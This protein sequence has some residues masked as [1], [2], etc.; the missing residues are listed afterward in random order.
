MKHNF[1]AALLAIPLSAALAIS[2]CGG[3]KRPRARTQPAPP[4]I[5]VEVPAEP[6]VQATEEVAS[7]VATEKPPER[8]ARPIYTEVGLASW[9]GPPYHN[10]KTSNGEIYDMHRLT[11]AHKTLPLNSIVRVT[12]PATG[13][14]VTVR[15]ND[16]G[17]FIGDRIIDL[18]LAAAKRIDVWRA[19]VAKV[20]VELLSAPAP[21]D[22]GGRWAVQIGA[23]SDRDEAE[24]LKSKL[25]RKY[26]TARVVQFTGPTGEWVRF[27]P[28]NDD[29]RRAY[30]VAAE[31]RV[32]EGGV[33]LVR[34]D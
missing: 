1:Q 16:R 28:L 15:I 26:Q 4:P 3:G 9:Y 10:G 6:P 19:G 25:S 20:K 8:E 30:Q 22:R 7:K 17:P 13:D 27:R 2:G 24:K 5:F 18:S 12:N 14:S 34:L 33:F 32:P 11:A 23:F 29:R 21:L 31:T